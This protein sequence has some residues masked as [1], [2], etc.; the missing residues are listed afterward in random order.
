MKISGWLVSAALAMGALAPRVAIAAAEGMA[1][2]VVA[3]IEINTVAATTNVCNGDPPRPMAPAMAEVR[4][5][6]RH[7]RTRDGRYVL[8]R[9]VNATGDSK[10]PP[11]KT[12]TSPTLLDPLPGWGINTLRFLFIWEAFEPAP[13]DFREDYLAY[14][15]QGV[16]WAAERGWTIDRHLKDPGISGYTGANL[17]ATADLGRLLAL[18]RAGQIPTGSILLVENLDRLSRMQPTEALKIFLTLTFK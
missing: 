13:C 10:L 1:A 9:G 4:A 2:A 14:Y 11:F 16:K 3:S 7:F 8:L 5:D 18:V 17:S 6:G 12:L 15:E